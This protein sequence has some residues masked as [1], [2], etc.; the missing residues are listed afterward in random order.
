MQRVA[1][2]HL[3][4]IRPFFE[5][6]AAVARNATCYRAHCGSVIVKDGEVIG[7]GYNSPVL[8]DETN[9]MCDEE[10]DLSVKRKYDKTCC[11]HAEWRAI[12]DACKRSAEKLG[13]SAL[14]FMRVDEQGNFTDAGAPYCTTC[15]RLALESGVGQFALWNGGGADVYDTA[16]YNRRSYSYFKAPGFDT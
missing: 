9:R 16:E 6:A 12:L 5:A 3:E 10:Y 14:Y 4:A 2:S 11:V 13:G 8:D 15:S 1:D 7:M